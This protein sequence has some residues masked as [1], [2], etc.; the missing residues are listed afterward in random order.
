MNHAEVRSRIADYLEGD[1][2]L[3]ERALFDG[4]LDG[5]EPCSREVTELRETIHL[6][7]SLPDPEPPPQLVEK[8]IRRI[9][10][11]EGSVRLSDRLHAAF[12]LL[13]RPQ[14]ALPATAVAAALVLTSGN[15]GPWLLPGGAGTPIELP[16]VALRWVSERWPALPWTGAAG[17]N[18][19]RVE[20]ATASR[21]A[22]N[23]APELEGSPVLEDGVNAL[24]RRQA[25]SSQVLA[26]HV[27]PP[28][29]A[30]APRIAI[31][32]PIGGV[33][34]EASP[35]RVVTRWPS[36]SLPGPALPL[37]SQR[38]PH[39][40]PAGGPVVPASGV[41]AAVRQS[42][43]LAPMGRV[44]E[45][46]QRKRAELEARLEQMIQRP[47]AYSRKF[48]SLTTI[49]QEIWLRALAEFALETNRAGEAIRG[50]RSSTSPV[51]LELATAF[52][53]ELRQMGAEE[54]PEVASAVEQR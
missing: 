49:E 48:A 25:A 42:A 40:E 52:E 28:A 21:I 36:R 15:F 18:P 8:V 41:D 13:A 16:Q 22:V 26:I 30:R 39:T 51:T 20:A 27:A 11:G 32:I 31:Q 54:R 17:T 44:A 1:L 33:L 3:S 5:C 45:R 53:A 14:V 47:V 34:Q 38:L 35:R 43:A 4:H 6:L 29:V 9:R 19:P 46:E 24:R 7:R 50:L 12:S 2:K 23:R 10:S 37:V